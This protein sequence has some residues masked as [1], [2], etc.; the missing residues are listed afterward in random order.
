MPFTRSTLRSFSKLYFPAQ[1]KTNR[2]LELIGEGFRID[3]YRTLASDQAYA[4]V[5]PVWD[6][7]KKDM[8]KKPPPMI[9]GKDGQ[10]PPRKWSKKRIPSRGEGNAKKKP[11]RSPSS[12]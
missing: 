10:P 6:A 1:K 5:L 8:D 9:G 11:K 12:S 2:T 7:L 3:R 4:L